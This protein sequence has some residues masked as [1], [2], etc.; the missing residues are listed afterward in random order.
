MLGAL[1][2][3][4]AAIWAP[5]ASEARTILPPPPAPRAAPGPL[6]GLAPRLADAIR[7]GRT[8]E[9]GVFGDSF[10]DG[11][12]WALTQQ[13]R[14][15]ARFRLHQLSQRS[16]GFAGWADMTGDFREKLDRQPLDVAVI[17]F[18]AN[19]THGLTV[20]G[21]HVDFLSD[22]WR[23]VVG[24]RLTAVVSLLRERGVQVYWVGLPRM[25]RPDFETKIRA[26]NG[27]YADR[28]Q[29][30][31]VPFVDTVAAT[32][33]DGGHYA[34]RLVNP[35]SGRPMLARAGDGIHMSM[36]GYRLLTRGLVRHLTYRWATGRADALRQA[37][38]Q[39]PPPSAG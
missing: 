18:G 33:D 13:L 22:E 15:D 19:D 31:A 11:I 10:G 27:F 16:T 2:L 36:N 8:V 34:E 37:A 24:A 23:Q 28:M 30:L 14:G 26:L 4:F 6:A 35:D 9:I 7:S 21:H 12:W 1:A 20:D 39:G 3:G 5:K 29:A 25:R 17:S 38:A 32:T